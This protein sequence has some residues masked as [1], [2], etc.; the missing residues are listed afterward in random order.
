VCEAAFAFL[1]LRSIHVAGRVATHFFV[2]GICRTGVGFGKE[3]D[4]TKE[5]QRQTKDNINPVSLPEKSWKQ[6]DFCDFFFVGL[7]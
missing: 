6:T 2:T 4:L 5:M 3:R 7:T 1:F